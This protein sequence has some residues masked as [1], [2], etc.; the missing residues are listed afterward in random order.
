[1]SQNQNKQKRVSPWAHI[2]DEL[3][4]KARKSN[5]LRNEIGLA[6]RDVQQE[7]Y[8]SYCAWEKEADAADA[9]EDEDMEEK[10][11]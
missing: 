9:K 8:E 5:D 1:M 10:A 11:E 3:A 2:A 4:E 7:A 6:F